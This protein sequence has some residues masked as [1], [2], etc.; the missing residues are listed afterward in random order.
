MAASRVNSGRVCARICQKY[1]YFFYFSFCLLSLQFFV[2]YNFYSLIQKKLESTEEWKRKAEEQLKRLTPPTRFQAK[3]S[4]F[5]KV[6]KKPY[7]VNEQIQWHVDDSVVK[8]AQSLNQSDKFKPNADKKEEITCVV[9]AKEARSAI[10]RA[11]TIECKQ[12]ITT[13]ACLAKAGRLYPSNLTSLCPF[14]G[15]YSKGHYFGCY[16]D[17]TQQRDLAVVKELA[18]NSPDN[19]IE[20]CLTA[21]YMYAGV[22]YTKE[23]WCGDMYGLYDK[24]LESSCSSKCPGDPTM[25][26]GG[27][28]SQRIFSTGLAEKKKNPA[29]LVTDVMS[30]SNDSIPRV[31]IVFVLTV[32]GRAVRQVK[33]LLNNIYHPQHYYYLHVD[34]R[35]QYMYNELKPL[36]EKLP[37]VRMSG[38]RFATIWGGASLLEAH[39]SF[40]KDL[41][42]FVDWHWDYYINLSES[43]YPIKTI[44]S[45]VSYLSQYKGLNFIKSHGRDTPTF[46]RKQGLNQNFYE[47]ENH[48]WRIGHRE[49][50]KGIRFDG[51]SDWVGLYRDFCRYALD[52]KDEV[53]IGLKQ[54]FNYTLL[55]VESFFHILLHNSVFC[56]MWADNNLHMTNWKRKQGCKCQYKHIVDW[57]GCSPND[58][59]AEDFDKILHNEGKPVFFARKFEPVVDQEIISMLDIHLFG[60]KHKDT[61]SFKHFWQNEYHHLDKSTTGNDVTR[62]FYDS[63]I[64]RAVRLFQNRSSRCALKV[65]KILEVNLLYNSDH[66]SGIVVQFNASLAEWQN[67]GT[68][69]IWMQPKHYYKILNPEGHIGRL[70]NLEVGTDVDPKELI[71]RNYARLMGPYSEVQLRHVWGKGPDFSVTVA[72]IDPTGVIAAIQDVSIP[73]QTHIGYSKPQLKTP[74]RP[75]VWTTKLLY[76]LEVV[77]E[78]Q[79]LVLPL[80]V[81]HGQPLRPSQAHMIH[82]GPNGL[83]ASRDF[84]EF[85]DKLNVSVSENQNQKAKAV[86]NGMKTGESLSD[87]IDE[88]S[89]KFWDVQESCSKQD[90]E[91]TCPLLNVCTMSHWSSMY[92]DPKSEMEVML[93]TT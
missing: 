43:D 93:D 86:I 49:L 76:K 90:I 6:T 29:S 7:R 42:S 24:V 18:Q 17:V 32:N 47:C 66:F 71:F 59:H 30:S 36:A 39:L 37:N 70:Q 27:Y 62:T 33:R 1:K 15:T 53:V 3:P 50:P 54:M 69:E 38:Q 83:Y 82:N 67:S 57:C 56:G 45:L 11:K 14:K 55:P 2:G 78:T 64:R 88:L 77:A 87:W 84:K 35:H 22:Q 26:C 81:L 41:L 9:D 73:T 34:S 68:I 52:S 72:W 92:P 85:Q 12:E 46:I 63:C 40:I 28:L 75:G 5:S 60:G 13:V 58:F 65:H 61:I 74:L 48:L 4:T 79:F 51:G 23:C 10:S 80:A 89:A 16:K 20:F 19:C 44:E 8:P 25:T 91:E 21:G 31:R